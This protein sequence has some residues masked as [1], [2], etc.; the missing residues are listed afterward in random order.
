MAPETI[1]K[2]TRAPPL[3]I[4]SAGVLLFELL[5][6]QRPFEAPAPFLTM[7]LVLEA[8]PDWALL[9]PS[10]SSFLQAQCLHPQ[11]SSRSPAAKLLTSEWTEGGRNVGPPVYSRPLPLNLY[12]QG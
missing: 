9:D 5:T 8:K 1:E 10:A 11:P 12:S 4:W 7:R 6:A 2:G 3:D